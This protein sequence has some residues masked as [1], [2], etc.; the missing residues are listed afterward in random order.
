M[1]GRLT[2]INPETKRLLNRNFVDDIT[3]NKFFKEINANI[4]I[5]SL[6]YAQND[7]SAEREVRL[8]GQVLQFNFALTS[9][10]TGEGGVIVIIHDVTRHERLESARR[11][12]I[13][14]GYSRG[15]A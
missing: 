9:R 14:R 1:K 10:D 15:H 6:Q 4:T 3:F 13:I 11:D 2:H 7:G 5:E 12:L 8:N